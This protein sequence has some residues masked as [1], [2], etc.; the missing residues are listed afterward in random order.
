MSNLSDLIEERAMEKGIEKGMEKGME[1]GIKKG[2]EKG[3]LMTI[4]QALDNGMDETSVK[5]FLNATDEQ[6]EKAKI[7]SLEA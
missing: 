5:K 3:T 2:I 7:F 4:R 1:K 6:I